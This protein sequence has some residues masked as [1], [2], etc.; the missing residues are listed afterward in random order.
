MFAR[1]HPQTKIKSRPPE[2]REGKRNS[3]GTPANFNNDREISIFPYV[4]HFYLGAVLHV[5]HAGNRELLALLM[6]R[7][8]VTIKS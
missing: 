2:P 1:A 3:G 4:Y 6:Y 7:W 5:L 8:F